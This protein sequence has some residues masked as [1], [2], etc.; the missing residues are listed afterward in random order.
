MNW[1]EPVN[2]EKAS[3]TKRQRT[4][5]SPM[6]PSV[7]PVQGPKSPRRNSLCGE[8]PLDKHEANYR[9]YPFNTVRVAAYY[10][11]PYSFNTL[12]TPMER[13][14]GETRF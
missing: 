4:E 2:T 12:Y 10:K 6:D 14:G 9:V 7:F 11:Q 13:R 1:A 8:K 5:R 3:P